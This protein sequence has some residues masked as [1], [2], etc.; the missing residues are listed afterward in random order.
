MTAANAKYTPG[1]WRAVAPKGRPSDYTSIVDGPDGIMVLFAGSPS[2]TDEEIVANAALAAAAPDLVEAL[3]AL[4]GAIAEADELDDPAI[5]AG[6]AK[7]RDALSKAG[8]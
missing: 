1:P 7:A 3:D 8:V 4:G 6:M 2:R 5:F